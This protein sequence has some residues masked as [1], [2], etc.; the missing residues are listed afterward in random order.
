MRA[1]IRYGGEQVLA[2]MAELGILPGSFPVLQ[3]AVDD[4]ITAIREQNE[5]N[6]SRDEAAAHLDDADDVAAHKTYIV[7]LG[8][9]TLLQSSAA[10]ILAFCSGRDGSRR[11]W[12]AREVC[13]TGLFRVVA[14]LFREGAHHVDDYKMAVL[15]TAARTV[16]TCPARRTPA[17]CYATLST[18]LLCRPVTAACS[19]PAAAAA[20]PQRA[21]KGRAD[22]G[23]AVEH[24]AGAV[25]PQPR[26]HIRRHSHQGA[27]HHPDL[28]D[29]LAGSPIQPPRQDRPA[30]AR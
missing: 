27:Q 2:M 21:A 8:A 26:G 10:H 24:H 16:G 18:V 12:G 15:K 4:I 29:A 20:W 7:S 3:G 9:L 11:F 22:A 14:Y 30:G 13:A 28:W 5:S 6:R 1:S 23:Q 25:V 19:A 17:C